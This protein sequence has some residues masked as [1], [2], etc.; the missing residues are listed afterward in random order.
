MLEELFHCSP[1]S[2][3]KCVIISFKVVLCKCKKKSLSAKL[4]FVVC[5]KCNNIVTLIDNDSF[6]ILLYYLHKSLL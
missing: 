4:H 1:Y 2:C 5:M 3:S 6:E